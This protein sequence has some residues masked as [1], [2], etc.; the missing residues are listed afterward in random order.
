M[1]TRLFVY[2]QWLVT[3]LSVARIGIIAFE[4]EQNRDQITGECNGELNY[5]AGLAADWV[6]NGYLYFVVWRFYVRMRLYPELMK[7][8]EFTYEEGLDEL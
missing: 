1:L 6:L 5:G 4:L 7:A 8:E 3:F 2:V